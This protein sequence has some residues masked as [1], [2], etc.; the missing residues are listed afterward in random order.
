MLNTLTIKARLTLLGCIAILGVLIA[1]GFGINRLASFDRQ[2]EEDLQEVREGIEMMLDITE[3]N[4]AFKTQVQE[5]KNILLRGDNS[6][7]FE[8]YKKSFL[9]SEKT[10]QEKLRA[11]VKAMQKEKN[12]LT[13]KAEE[14][15]KLH[16]ELGQVYAKEI[17]QWDIK[18][19]A[20]TKK[21]D[22]ALSG[23]DRAASE[24]MTKLVEE[25]ENTEREHLAAQTKQAQEIYLNS[26]N[27]MIT[28]ISGVLLIVLVLVVATARA[29][30][31][32][33]SILQSAL[34]EMR[35]SMDLSRRLPAT[36]GDEISA[37]SRSVN[38]LLADFHTVVSTMKDS[39]TH[40]SAA[41][42][43]LAGS[44]AQLSDSV[45]QQNE[46]TASMAASVEELA[47]SVTH[48][49][50]SSASAQKI[51]NNSL[52]QAEEGS[53][54]IGRT[55]NG[56]VGMMDSLKTTSTTVEE[57]GQRSQEIGSIAGVIKEIADQT[58]LLALNAA[59]EAARAGEQGRGF[60]VVADEVRKLAE[61]TAKATTEIATVI[62]TIQGDTQKT[63]HDMQNVVLLANENAA[64][65][66]QAGEAIVGIRNGSGEVV[67]ATTDISTALKEQTAASDLIARQVEVIATMSDENT[68]ALGSVKS[69]SEEMKQLSDEMHRTVDRFKV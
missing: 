12:P 49:S 68:A 3:A 67:N 50:D 7:S 23:K 20:N 45:G 5:W 18:D 58:N 60:A 62:N 22:Q 8:R 52:H 28:L 32:Q 59:I 29:I 6:E 39:A 14:V 54:V 56:M 61:R 27:T 65:A 34:S 30:N 13:G 57:L 4:I 53:Q 51:S 35:S 63:V 11:A 1:G 48:I 21:G 41:S 16:A 17:A 44:V 42:D 15:I 10:V 2:L 66:R 25:M 19:P 37:V 55:V 64:V 26:R 69:A 24:A 46:A 47:V 31:L 9:Q 38:E 36:G 33:I 40:V 43:A